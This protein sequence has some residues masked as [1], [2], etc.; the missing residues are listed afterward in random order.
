MKNTEELNKMDN[1]ILELQVC[2]FEELELV[3]SINGYNKQALNDI[4]Y[5]RTGYQDLDQYVEYRRRNPLF[6]HFRSA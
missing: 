4:V 6:N 2:T 3:T 5:S 1:T